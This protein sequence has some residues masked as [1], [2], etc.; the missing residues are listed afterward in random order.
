MRSVL[1]A[2]LNSFVGEA[3][4]LRIVTKGTEMIARILAAPVLCIALLVS[5]CQSVQTT[6]PG[7]VGIERKQQ[8]LVSE[9]DVEKGAAQAYAQ[10]VQKARKAGKLNS[11]PALT[12]RV[13]AISQRLIPATRAFR[14]DAP[15]WKWEINTLTTNEMNAYAMPGG[16]IM[17]Y[18]GLVDRLK[19]TDAELAAVIGHEISHALR[20]HTRERVSRAYAQQLALTGIAIATGAGQG[21]LDLANEVASVTFELPHSREQE[22]EADI[23]GL[24]LMARAGY[25]PNAAVNV[26]KKMMAAEKTGAPEFLSTHPAP[27]NRIAELQAS[28]PKVLPLY[29]AANL[30]R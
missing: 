22:S 16:K 10:Q 13:R 20:E 23:M 1:A 25:D 30:R 21:T 24:E 7:A 18:S 15:G 27:A 9:Q 5:G 6:A 14:P 29:Q 28:V 26:W 11:N 12:T 8:M 4:R 3:W 17:V 19:L 2:G